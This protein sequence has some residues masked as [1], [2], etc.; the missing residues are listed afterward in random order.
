MQD[1]TYIKQFNSSKIIFNKGGD[2]YYF[3]KKLLKRINVDTL[4]V[5]ESYFIELEYNY[6]LNKRNFVK[7]V[8]K[9]IVIKEG[10]ISKLIWELPDKKKF[11]DSNLTSEVFKESF[12]IAK[13]SLRIIKSPTD[14]IKK[15]FRANTSYLEFTSLSK[16]FLITIFGDFMNI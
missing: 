1:N 8:L 11:T 6:F 5:G 14:L 12:S 9:K 4:V 16:D 3:L 13:K 7:V 2:S 10:I 15:N